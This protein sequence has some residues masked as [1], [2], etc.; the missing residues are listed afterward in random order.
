MSIASLFIHINGDMT[1][2]KHGAQKNKTLN[3]VN[4]KKKKNIKIHLCTSI[5]MS[6]VTED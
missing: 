2:E 5:L 6:N 4:K 1:K 3:K